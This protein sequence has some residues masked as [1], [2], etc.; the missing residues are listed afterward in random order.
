MSLYQRLVDVIPDTGKGI[1]GGCG[2]VLSMAPPIS[3]VLSLEVIARY[4]EGRVE[5]LP[6]PALPAPHTALVSEIFYL[7]ADDALKSNDFL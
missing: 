7:L 5:S 1:V 4:I 2:C 6:H 3:P